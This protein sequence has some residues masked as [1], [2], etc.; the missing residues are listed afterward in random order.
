MDREKIEE[1][2]EFEVFN[3]L[4]QHF[5]R[6]VFYDLSYSE[7]SKEEE[8]KSNIHEAK[9]TFHLI[10]SFI[11]LC[12]NEAIGLDNLK[13]KIG[14]ITPYRSQVR[15]LYYELNQQKNSLGCNTNDIM[16]STVDGF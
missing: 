9:F 13:G 12:G 4:Q 14:L 3:I 10:R 2:P 11:Y 15:K 1:F 16:I 8:S 6:L 5:S 7:E